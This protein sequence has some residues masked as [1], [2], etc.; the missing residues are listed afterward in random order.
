MHLVIVLLILIETMLMVLLSLM[1][2]QD[3]ENTSG[4]LLLFLTKLHVF[5]FLSVPVLTSTQQTI[6]HLP[7]HLWNDYF[8]DTG[9]TNSASDI[10]YSDDPLWDGAG[11]GPQSTYM[12]FL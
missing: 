3:K 1:E 2:D 12:L 10:F 9:S 11:C 4:H 7:H 5:Q 8:C 6:P